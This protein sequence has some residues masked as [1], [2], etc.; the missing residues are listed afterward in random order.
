MGDQ[1]QESNKRISAEP[2]EMFTTMFYLKASQGWR[3]FIRLRPWRVVPQALEADEALEL[4]NYR[5]VYA[6]RLAQIT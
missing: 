1:T 2:L 6:H 4:R 3:L 5:A